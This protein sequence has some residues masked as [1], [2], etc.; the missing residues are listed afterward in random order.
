METCIARLIP[1][2]H[3]RQRPSAEVTCIASSAGFF[4]VGTSV[5]IVLVL[6]LPR[7]EGAPL[8]NGELRAVV[9]KL[10]MLVTEI[11][12][13]NMTKPSPRSRKPHCIA[14]SVV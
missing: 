6:A 10:L 2:D 14:G 9:E 12:S 1:S 3:P 8:M 7:L 11:F 5:G 4:W 13:S